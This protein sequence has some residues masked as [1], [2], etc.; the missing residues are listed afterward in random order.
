MYIH[1]VHYYTYMLHDIVQ[2][3]M[4]MY[5]HDASNKHLL[6]CIQTRS[7][8]AKIT[9]SAPLSA[10]KKCYDVRVA[11]W[12]QYN[13]GQTIHYVVKDNKVWGEV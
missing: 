12:H 3:H 10:K 7:M 9:L 6:E 11:S 2:L 5:M 8:G 1:A 4:T 13:N